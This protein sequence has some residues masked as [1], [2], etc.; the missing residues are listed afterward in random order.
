MADDVTLPGTGAAVATDEVDLGS[1]AA[2]VQMMKLV[3]GTNGGTAR[4][5][6]TVARGLS[7][8][9]RADVVR[10]SV[11]PTISTSAYAA[12]DNIG[13]ILE[14]TNL[15][16]SSGGACFL[17]N[18]QIVDKAQQMRDVDLVLFDRTITAPTDNAVFDPTDTE[19]GYVLGWI[20]VGPGHYADFSDN[21]VADVAIGKR[22]VLNGTSL[23]GVLVARTLPPTYVSTSDLVVTITATRD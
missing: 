1:G 8:D 3:D 4:I 11:T 5:P 17:E 13:G 6:G 21:A 16:R 14:F 23:F 15:A 22:V 10:S 7:V 12:K 9:P 20:G 2:H 18:V 19:L